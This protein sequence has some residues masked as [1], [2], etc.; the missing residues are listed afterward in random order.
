MMLMSL[1]WAYLNYFCGPVLKIF[2]L[3]V[4]RKHAT[5][6]VTLIGFGLTVWKCT[7]MV[8]LLVVA[9]IFGGYCLYHMLNYSDDA[10]AAGL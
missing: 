1:F 3:S 5:A 7:D 6:L 2:G 4:S 8:F 10:L 9:A